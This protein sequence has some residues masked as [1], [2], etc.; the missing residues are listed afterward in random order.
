MTNAATR[1]A[2]RRNKGRSPRKRRPGLACQRSTRSRAG[3]DRAGRKLTVV[4]GNVSQAVKSKTVAID[5]QG[6]VVPQ[7]A[8]QS[9]RYFAIL[10]VRAASAA[11]QREAGAAF[12]LHPD[13]VTRAIRLNTSYAD[14]MGWG[15]RLAAITS[16]IAA[17]GAP[18]AGPAFAHVVAR[19][20]RGRG[21]RADG[22]VG[23]DSWTEMARAID[24]R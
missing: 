12:T 15:G 24:H 16:L 13:N 11:P 23:P 5:A 2:A 9:G 1:L 3:P 21:L 7:Q 10:K 22:V 19:W 18:P 17:P 14:V 6:F 20:Q 4:G 8:G